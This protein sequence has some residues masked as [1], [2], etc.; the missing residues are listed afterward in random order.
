MDSVDADGTFAA[1]NPV[2]FGD[3][4]KFV[5]R[6]AEQ[7]S[8]F[9]YTGKARGPRPHCRTSVPLVFP[10]VPTLFTVFPDSQAKL[11]I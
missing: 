6:R 9:A 10:S 4:P 11:L 7:G 8:P 1:R 3:F 5:V 2:A